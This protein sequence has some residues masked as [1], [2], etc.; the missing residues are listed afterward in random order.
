MLQCDLETGLI[1]PAKQILSPNHNDRPTGVDIDLL[2][3]HGISL[4]AGQFGG[5][6]IIDLF[7]NR[8]NPKAHPSFPDISKLRVASH[9][10]IRRD[11]E[12]IQFVPFNK[13]AFHAGESSFQGRTHCNDFSIGIEL[14]GTDDI[15][16]TTQQYDQLAKVTHCICSA[17]PGITRERIKG[18]SDIAPHRKTDPGPSF[19]WSQY[20][21]I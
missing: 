18:H 7:C 9:L 5:T 10:L 21:R 8:L 17:Y 13:R 16:Y 2:I 14:E 6:E 20:L 4:P 19:D 3:I 12:L 1:H 11:G 15:P